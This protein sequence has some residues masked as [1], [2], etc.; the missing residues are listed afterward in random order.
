MKLVYDKREQLFCVQLESHDTE[1]AVVDA[2]LESGAVHGV[3][4]Q[5]RVQLPGEREPRWLNR[6]ELRRF[7]EVQRGLPP[8]L[9]HAA[10]CLRHTTPE[11]NAGR[12][13]SYRCT[14]GAARSDAY[15]GNGKRR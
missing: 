9:E 1:D 6:P 5:L 13:D 12:A 11:L 4:A 2:A 8:D 3:N 15:K 10:R 14:C 7:L